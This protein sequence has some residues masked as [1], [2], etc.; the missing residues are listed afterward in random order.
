MRIGQPEDGVSGRIEARANVAAALITLAGLGGRVWAASGT[1]LN[2]DEALHFRLANQASLAQAYKQSLTGLHPPLFVLLLHLWR[3][4]GTSDLW[5]R[6]PS[7]IAGA[8]FCWLFFKWLS[9]VAGPLAGFLGLILV[10]LL[11]PEIALS[12]EVR[13]YALLLA[14]LGAALYLLERGFVENSAGLML[15][16]MLSLYLAMLTHY[17]A[18]LFA[19]ALGCYGL[20]K[21]FVPSARRQRASVSASWIVGQ[22][23]GVALCAFLYETHLSR[24]DFGESEILRGWMAYLSRSS[25]FQPGRDNP[26][27]YAVGHSFGVFQYLF[28]QLTVGIVMGVTFLVGLVLL[29]RGRKSSQKSAPDPWL[30][31]LLVLPF[32]LACAASFLHV[33]PYGGTRHVAFLTLPAMT[34]VS[35][36]LAC[37]SG[38]G[39]TGKRWGRGVAI[40]SLVVIACIV[41]GK[42]RQPRM[43]R[44]DQSTAHM[45][46]AMQFVQTKIGPSDFIYTDYQTDLILGRY[47]CPERPVSFD[48]APDLFEQFS[49]GGHRIISRDF[50]GWMFGADSFPLEW[51]RFVQ[52]YRPKP[53]DS[54][55]IIQAGWGADLPEDL[56]RYPEFRDLGFEAFGN[57]IK[58]FKMPAGQAMPAVP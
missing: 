48:V 49:C 35:L 33:Y 38:T 25:Y 34:G 54:V 27:L 22:L 2:P 46:A 6:L 55:W 30:A 18:F 11:P 58:I 24:R 13:Q 57:N 39:A 12:A 28:G 1:F 20:S 4:L 19:G 41:F 56:R 21:I 45:A 17:S 31:V 10:A 52:A 14:F 16:S 40:T 15:A 8:V 32:V 53:G 5:L 3:G 37:L 36:A 44:A 29:L 43:E 26:V 47:L 42:V 50:R 7:V 51:Q 23:G 9:L